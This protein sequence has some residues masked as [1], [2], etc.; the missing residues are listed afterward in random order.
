VHITVIVL[1]FPHGGERA[2]INDVLV[3]VVQLFVNQHFKV[4]NTNTFLASRSVKYQVL[5]SFEQ[6]DYR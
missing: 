5:L 3:F 6:A 4:F 2:T 1:I